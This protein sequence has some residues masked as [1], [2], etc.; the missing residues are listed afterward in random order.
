MENIQVIILIGMAIVAI[1][2]QV[3]KAGK[4]PK[5]AAPRKTVPTDELPDEDFD[6]LEPEEEPL[7]PP[8]P[9]DVRR[10]KPSPRFGTVRT[11]HVRT[12][13]TPAPPKAPKPTAPAVKLSTREEARRAFLYAEIFNRKY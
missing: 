13:A 2:Q 6:L 8:P 3:Q 4:Q 1:V 7:A 10:P 9:A 11:P 5:T 12:A